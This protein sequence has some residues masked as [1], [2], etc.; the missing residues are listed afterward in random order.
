MFTLSWKSIL[1][2]LCKGNL[3]NSSV[4]QVYNYDMKTFHE[5]NI[6]EVD[7]VIQDQIEEEYIFLKIDYLL[8]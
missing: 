8:G 1:W 7:Y 2:Y 3:S 4:Y 6:C 5:I